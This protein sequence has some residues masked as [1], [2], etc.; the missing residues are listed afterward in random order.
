MSV[1]RGFGLAALVAAFLTSG[2]FHAPSASAESATLHSGY[3]TVGTWWEVAEGR[4]YWAGSFWLTSYNNAGSGFGHKNVWNCPAT[5]EV[6]DG[7]FSA[8][9]YCIMTDPDGDKIFAT[10]VGRAPAGEEFT[11]HQTYT[12]GTGKYAGI[13]GGHD[14]FCNGVGTDEQGL[15]RQEVD[16]T[17]P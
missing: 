10:F 5:G 13:S 6:A 11:G 3:K 16:F 14:F 15:C 17:L 9:G 2:L 12:G 1:L 7:M 4:L 8:T